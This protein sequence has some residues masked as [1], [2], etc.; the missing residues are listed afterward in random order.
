M[1]VLI[2]LLPKEKRM[3]PSQRQVIINY[4]GQ[5]S[6]VTY[7]SQRVL[8]NNFIYNNWFKL[9]QDLC[10][11]G[12]IQLSGARSDLSFGASSSLEIVT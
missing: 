3:S 11:W 12:L 9:V 6:Y 4:C 10:Y 8:T 7:K 5:V 2:N 1:R